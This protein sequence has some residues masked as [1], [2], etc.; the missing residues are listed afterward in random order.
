M[1]CCAVLLAGC[2][3]TG[4]LPPEPGFGPPAPASAAP[5]HPTPTQQAPVRIAPG[6]LPS[7]T[8]PMP[9]AV[10]FR[11]TRIDA[12]DASVQNWEVELDVLRAGH[13]ADEDELF[14]VWMTGRPGEDD[15]TIT[16]IG[17]ARSSDGARSFTGVDVASPISQ[18]AI[19]FDPIVAQDP[20]TQR[21]LVSVME[22]TPPF[23]RQLWV[24]RSEPG[25]GAQ[26]ETGRLL[27]LAPGEIPDKGWFAIGRDPLEPSRTVIHLAT[28]AGMRA[29]RDG[30]ETWEGP[31]ALPGSSN[32][33][34]PVA[35][36]DGTLLVAYLGTGGQALLVR[37]GDGGRTYSAP[38]AIHTFV[39][40]IGDLSNPAL[41]GFF[42]A[43]PTTVLAPA[44]G[45]RLYAALH[46]ITERDGAEAGLDVLLFHSDDGGQTWSAGRNVTLDSPTFTDQF[47]P[48]LSVDADGRLHLAYFDARSPDGTDAHPVALV[49][50]WYARS[51]DG[52]A[53]WSRTRLTAS[54][55]DSSG[56]R[57]APTGAQ[58]AQ[59]LGDYFTLAL[60][61]H[62]AYVAHPVQAQGVYGMAVS[63]IDLAA[64]AT[65]IRDPRG[66]TGPW[67]EPA[68][69]GQGFEFTW[70]AGDALAVAFYGH[71]DN[72]ANLFLTGVR[73]GRFAYGDTLE[74]PLT[75]VTGGRF[76]GFDRDAIRTAAWGRLTL[77][78]DSCTRA[79]ARLEG[80][81]GSKEMQLE[82]LA[83]VPSLPCD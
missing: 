28:R 15:R 44:P 82:R 67:Y 2:A 79:V 24:A 32:L 37:S 78:F 81:D 40:D 13:H 21:T 53:T 75:T 4:P 56:T 47:L 33:L 83:R 27:P 6:Y 69:S 8:V 29:S 39:G 12:L 76:N 73:A 72:G 64:D 42:R 70:I 48:T 36:D 17:M 11:Q 38:R 57:W 31:L 71:R 5:A 80:A 9:K 54:P 7:H 52:G 65:P 10:A 19:P 20:S 25:Q 1:A 63:R 58:D 18:T 66:L 16:G 51:D 74:I 23:T 55:I 14:A 59:F 41:P 62:A 43:P 30:G 3:A 34:Q 60:S 46:D 61:P 45:G 68:T 49:D 77:R 22:Q 26:F 35:L 50:A